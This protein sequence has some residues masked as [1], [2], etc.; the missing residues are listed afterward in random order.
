MGI[1]DFS[2]AYYEQTKNNQQP[3]TQ[4]LQGNF[5]GGFNA[6]KPASS[7]KSG[8]TQWN[9]AWNSGYTNANSSSN[10]FSGKVVDGYDLGS[11]YL[12]GQQKY[13]SDNK[14]T[15]NDNYSPAPPSNYNSSP[16]SSNNNSGGQDALIS[17]MMAKG[18]SRDSAL[19]AL[20]GRGYESLA[21][22]YL[23]AS[24]GG[25]DAALKAWQDQQRGVIES[26]YNEYENRLK[27]MQGDISSSRDQHISTAE[28]TYS[29]IFG[30]L[31]EQKGANLEK[32]GAGRQAV[33]QR[34]SESIEDLKKN[35]ADVVR[36]TSMQLGAIGAGDTSAAK[37]MMPYA[38][39][40]IAGNEEG[41]IR[42]QANQQFFDIDQ[43]ERD[44]NLQYSQMWKDTEIEKN[45]SIQEIKDKYGAMLQNIQYSL[46]QAPLDKQKDL[47]NLNQAIL[48]EAYNKLATLEAEDRQNKQNLKTWATNRL[49]E[50]NNAKLTMANSAKFTPEDILYSEL[51]MPGAIQASSG[52]ENM[53]NI[54]YSALAKKIREDYLS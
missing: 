32:L 15:G 49:S 40:K 30:G 35:L 48:G 11:G 29:K 47:F 19:A 13:F 26:G 28:D 21:N 25:S 45:N 50:L 22:E 39:T 43:E 36:G 9:E 16:S 24:N 42:R 23:G 12:Q 46:A 41:G 18:H 3:S 8:S 53:A 52:N 10:P 17:A 27:G 6:N 44:T 37:V 7:A 4:Q 38:Y 33:S 34:Q 31:D 51:K 20:S 54:N 2:N 5:D 1:F 14:K